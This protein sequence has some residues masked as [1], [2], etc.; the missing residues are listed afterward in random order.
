LSE[1]WTRL[2]VNDRDIMRAFRTFNA[3]TEAFRR[4]SE[5]HEK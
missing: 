3:N 2:G 4:E 1:W 5:I